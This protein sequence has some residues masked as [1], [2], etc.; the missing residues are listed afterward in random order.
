MPRNSPD[1]T[2]ERV[3][4]DMDDASVALGVSVPVIY[5]L[6]ND[7]TL[8]TVRIG[9]RRFTSPDMLRACVEKLRS[10]GPTPAPSEVPN[11]RHRPRGVDVATE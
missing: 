7:G 8:E 10:R 2:I 3:L 4:F 6:V 1:A 5:R 11:N 9:V